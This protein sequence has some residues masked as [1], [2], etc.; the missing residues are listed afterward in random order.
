M[1]S[2]A[3]FI[4]I[5]KALNAYYNA[6]YTKHEVAENALSYYWAYRCDNKDIIAFVEFMIENMG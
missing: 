6:G 4:H 3:Y 2:I 5:A 1:K